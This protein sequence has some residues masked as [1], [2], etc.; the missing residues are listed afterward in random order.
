MALVVDGGMPLIFGLVLDTRPKI[1]LEQ[2]S[3]R[4]Q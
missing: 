1:C 3:L 2:D 4:Q